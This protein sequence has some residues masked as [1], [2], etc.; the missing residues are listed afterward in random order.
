MTISTHVLDTRIGMPAAGMPFILSSA[1]NTEIASGTTNEDGRTNDLK[2]VHL[3]E[4]LYKMVFDTAK[5]FSS[6]GVKD[7]FYPKVE[8]NFLVVDPSSHYHVP[9]ILS[10]FG[11]STYRGS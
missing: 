11:F 10:P 9:L 8:L 4:G 3:E 1:E 5:Y 7:Y 6:Q 2:G